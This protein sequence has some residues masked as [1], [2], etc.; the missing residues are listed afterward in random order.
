MCVI[1]HAAVDSHLFLA[2]GA[3]VDNILQGVNAEGDQTT[4]KP[5]PGILTEQIDSFVKFKVCLSG[6]VWWS[7]GYGVIL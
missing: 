3:A 5:A 7:G 1:S 6:H 2:V 4:P